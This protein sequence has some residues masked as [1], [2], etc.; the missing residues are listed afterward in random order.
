M[1]TLP[2]P[3]GLLL[4][5]ILPLLLDWIASLPKEKR[6]AFIA[7]VLPIIEEMFTDAESKHLG[8]LPFSFRYPY[9]DAMEDVYSLIEKGTP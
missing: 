5:W 9:L 7:A 2:G 6:P 4:D 8:H 1:A 3:V